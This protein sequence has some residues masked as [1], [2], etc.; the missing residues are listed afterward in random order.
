MKIQDATECCLGCCIYSAELTFS[1][2]SKV[3]IEMARVMIQKIA[4]TDTNIANIHRKYADI[5][6]YTFLDIEIKT[7]CFQLP[8]ISDISNPIGIFPWMSFDI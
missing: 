7:K 3:F 1:P 5:N 4:N 2:C 8:T 6:T